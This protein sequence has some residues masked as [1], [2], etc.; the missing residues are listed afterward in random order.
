MDS[1]G[2]SHS[3]TGTNISCFLCLFSSLSLKWSTSFPLLIHKTELGVEEK[4]FPIASFHLEIW[5]QI[6]DG[7]IRN[8]VP[9]RTLSVPDSG[10]VAFCNPMISVNMKTLQRDPLHSCS[11]SCLTAV[12]LHTRTQSHLHLWSLSRHG[13]S[14]I[15]LRLHLSR[16]PV[17]N[18]DSPIMS[19]VSKWSYRTHIPL[20]LK[21]CTG[22][23][24]KSQYNSQSH[25]SFLDLAA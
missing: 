10:L 18:A 23:P 25:F 21:L 5:P 3:G 6:Y 13:S 15:P 22:W 1:N 4:C 8:T 17:I 9:E 20:T 12:L 11:R 2:I 7:L 24:W 14:S 16:H 19:S